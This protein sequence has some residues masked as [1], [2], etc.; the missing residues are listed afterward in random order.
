MTERITRPVHPVAVWRTRLAVALDALSA[1]SDDPVPELIRS[2][3]VET[4]SVQLP[5]GDRL[6]IPT[7]AETFRLKGYLLLSRNTRQDFAEFAELV[8]S[9]DAET[10]ADV[11]ARMDE[12]YCGRW[13]ECEPPGRPWVSTRLV[14]RLA[15]PDPRDGPGGFAESAAP[16]SAAPG[17]AP[18]GSGT[19]AAAG[20]DWERIRERCLSV[21][22]AMLEEAR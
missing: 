2:Q 14:R 4:A 18:P 3:P 10:V 22:V 8:E 11:L 12:Y 21:A 6:R 20:R 5:T 9:T 16:G 19:N 1:Q 17:A 15:D 13:S 7:C